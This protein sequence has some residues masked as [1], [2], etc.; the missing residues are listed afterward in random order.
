MKLK[1]FYFIMLFTYL[2][3]YSQSKVSRVLWNKVDNLPVEYATINSNENYTITNENGEFEF[4]KTSE[5]ITIQNIAYQKLEIDYDFLIK[6]D[7]IYIEPNVYELDEVI[8]EKDSE[9]NNMLRTVLTDYALEPHQEKF[10]LRATIKKNNQ[11]YKIV[12][13]SGH[14]E[15]QTLFDTRTKPMPKKNY[16]VQIDNIRK[17]GFEN[18]EYD[19]E[20]FSFK[21]LLNRIASTYLSP[22]IYNLS[23]EKS[24]INNF[25][26]IIVTP[27][28]KNETSTTGYYLV[29]ESN[30]TFNEVYILNDDKDAEFD[31][32]RDIKFRSPFLELKS[33]FKRNIKT[34]KLQ[35]NQAIIKSKTEVYTKDGKDIFEVNYIF[36]AN[37]I[38]EPIKIKNNINLRKD[39]FELKGNYDSKYWEDNEILLL[40]KEMQEFINKVNTSNNKSDFRTQT[41][42]K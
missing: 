2:N 36:Y 20:L 11:F 12:D 33:N 27:K 15:K 26:K 39:M 5:K 21:T 7:T 41:N 25:M 40:T 8:I 28:N 1:A 35:L 29:N 24:T 34:N 10:F 16:I 22:K 32:I 6:N 19:F 14:L 3:S 42:M 38:P 37:P 17:A 18:R 9:F 13:F 4:E 23:Y 31:E 30:N